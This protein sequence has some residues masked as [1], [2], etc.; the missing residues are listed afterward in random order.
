VTA[1]AAA[2]E[3]RAEADQKTGRIAGISGIV[4]GVA[5]PISAPPIVAAVQFATPSSGFRRD[6]HDRREWS[7]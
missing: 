4:N 6:R 3:A 1:G 2:A 5:S 7:G